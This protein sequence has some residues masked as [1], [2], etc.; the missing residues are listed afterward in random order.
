MGLCDFCSIC[1]PIPSPS[2]VPAPQIRKAKASGQ[3]G[4]SMPGNGQQQRPVHEGLWEG[5][6]KHLSTSDRVLVM[7]LRNSFN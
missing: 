1:L 2:P 7:D 4:Q 5:M 3:R 6:N